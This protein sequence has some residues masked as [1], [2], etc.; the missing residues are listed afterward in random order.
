MFIWKS[1]VLNGKIVYIFLL[2]FVFL[3][4][5]DLFLLGDILVIVVLF[6]FFCFKILKI[7]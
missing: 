3:D 7:N 4:V 2:D 6:K 1:I 5:F